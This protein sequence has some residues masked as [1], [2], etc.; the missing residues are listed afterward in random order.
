MY[1][2]LYIDIVVI[3][4]VKQNTFNH[5][6]KCLH[7]SLFFFL[8]SFTL[9]VFFFAFFIYIIQNV[10]LERNEMQTYKIPFHRLFSY[11]I[12]SFTN[13]FL[14]LNIFEARIKIWKSTF[15]FSHL[16]G[17]HIV[18]K[19][20]SFI[21]KHKQQECRQHHVHTTSHSSSSS[22]YFIAVITVAKNSI[23]KRRRRKEK[24]SWRVLFVSTINFFLFFFSRYRCTH[25]Q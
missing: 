4:E 5:D 21:V 8:S 24:T 3:V 17:L 6:W 12:H 2:F 15:H 13:N 10:Q 18:H 19:T 25:T 7:F 9:N 20:F 14:F 1:P 11:T 16:L 22:F 23:S